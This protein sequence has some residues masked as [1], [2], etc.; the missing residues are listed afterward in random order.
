MRE[1]FFTLEQTSGK[2]KYIQ[3]LWLCWY[4][5]NAQKCGYFGF[6]WMPRDKYKFIR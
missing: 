6:I 5:Q 2:V 1:K 3:H 4:L